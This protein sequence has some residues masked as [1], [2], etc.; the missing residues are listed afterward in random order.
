MAAMQCACCTDGVRLA[1]SSQEYTLQLPSGPRY[2]FEMHHYCG[3]AVLNKHG[4]PAK[5]QPSPNHPFWTAVTL[6]NQQGRHV[7]AEGLCVWEPER[8]PE[9]IDLGGGN[10]VIKGSALDPA[11]REEEA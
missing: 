5:Y 6:W 7:D 10:Y 9:V 4:D 8:E 1:T 2:V 11:M 3:P